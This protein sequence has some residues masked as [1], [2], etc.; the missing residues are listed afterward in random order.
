MQLRLSTVGLLALALSIPSVT[1]G[2]E[3]QG[4][5]VVLISIHADTLHACT[6]SSMASADALGATDSSLAAAYA[7]FESNSDVAIVVYAALGIEVKRHGNAGAVHEVSLSA[8]LED[9]LVTVSDAYGNVATAA[10]VPNALTLT[11]LDAGAGAAAGS[12]GGTSSGFYVS[13]QNIDTVNGRIS[14]ASLSFAQVAV[15]S[16]NAS[17]TTAGASATSVASGS[18]EAVATALADVRVQ[19]DVMFQRGKGK[20]NDIIVLND[21]K[22]IM[23]CTTGTTVTAAAQ[24]GIQAQLP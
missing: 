4:N 3:R 24:S 16:Q 7:G 15:Q 21:L 5:T 20:A 22:A 8:S 1:C 10:A 18:V 11:D 9:A 23:N 17:M 14:T 13:G 6:G 2:I 19:S 12:S